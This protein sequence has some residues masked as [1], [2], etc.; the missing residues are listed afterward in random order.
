MTSFVEEYRKDLGTSA[1]LVVWTVLTLW[2]GLSGPFGTYEALPFWLRLGYW[3]VNIGVGMVVGSG[4]R[5][6]VAAVLAPMAFRKQVVISSLLSSFVTT[7][8]LY[9]FSVVLLRGWAP[10]VPSFFEVMVFVFSI[11]FAVA[12]F[13]KVFASLATDK[14]KF[15]EPELPAP[16]AK[17]LSR[18]L[19]RIEPDLRGDLIAISVRDHYVDVQTTAGQSSLL[20]RLSDAIAEVGDV[21]GTQVHR[22]HWVA[23]SAVQGVERE[24]HKLYVR[25][26][27]GERL[28]V[29][30]NHREKLEA[31][32]LV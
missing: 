26:P 8:I 29:S 28:P 20:M 23:W 7:P 6:F 4:A 24:A 16:A 30:R 32:G 9:T 13:R 19:E 1:S 17:P 5:A 10:Y 3:A 25:L 21:G 15:T 31:R 18:L 11:S 2:L 27:C 22:S 14:P 12:S